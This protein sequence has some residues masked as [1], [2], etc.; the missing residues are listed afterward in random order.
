MLK[1]SPILSGKSKS[2][3]KATETNIVHADLSL[4]RLVMEKTPHVLLAGHGA[5][6]FAEEQGIPTLPPGDLVSDY[7]RS[8]L[9]AFKKGAQAQTEIGHSDVC[10][11]I[12]TVSI[13]YFVYVCRIKE[14]WIQLVL[15]L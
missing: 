12:F 13:I 8:A 10:T 11:F 2:K 3:P 4:A 9:E 7:A 6:K 14:R 15:W 1:I 5:N